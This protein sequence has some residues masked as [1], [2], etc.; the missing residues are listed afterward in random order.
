MRLVFFQLKTLLFVEKQK[1]FELTRDK[2][3]IYYV[4]TVT[5][6]EIQGQQHTQMI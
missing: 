5:S 6:H 2:S 4:N 1:Q 3:R